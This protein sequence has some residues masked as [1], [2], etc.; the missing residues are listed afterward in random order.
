MDVDF[1]RWSSE[2]ALDHCPIPDVWVWLLYVLNMNKHVKKSC[3]KRVR[4]RERNRNRKRQ[5]R[6]RDRKIV[7]KGQIEQS[8]LSLEMT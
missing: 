3:R 5:R 7:T 1:Y 2:I 4:E 6:E 8:N